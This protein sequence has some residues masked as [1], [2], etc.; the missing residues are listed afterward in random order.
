MDI[1]AQDLFPL[2][3]K[4]SRQER[5]RLAKMAFSSAAQDARTDAAV[6]QAQPVQ[7]D[8]FSQTGADP[9]TW[10]ADGWE[11]IK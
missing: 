6:Y 9:L 5:V 4:L 1:T 10:D 7:T 8:E 2:V 3:L 11:D